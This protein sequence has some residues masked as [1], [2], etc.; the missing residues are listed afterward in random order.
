MSVFLRYKAFC[1]VKHF[2]HNGIRLAMIQAIE[3]YRVCPAFDVERDRE[4][5]LLEEYCCLLKIHFQRIAEIV[6]V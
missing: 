3:E 4:V 1:A 5:V 6:V 2:C